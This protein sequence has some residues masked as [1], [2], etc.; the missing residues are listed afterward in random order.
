MES[1][2]HFTMGD[3]STDFEKSPGDLRQEETRAT[4]GKHLLGSIFNHIGVQKLFA[5]QGRRGPSQSVICRRPQPEPQTSFEELNSFKNSE[6]AVLDYSPKDIGTDELGLRELDKVERRTS[7]PFEPE[8]ETTD[9]I[10][11]L[12]VSQADDAEAVMLELNHKSLRL[13]QAQVI[14]HIE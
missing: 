13:L 12:N 1:F 5:S 14:D 2:I 11:S 8:P 9:N 7:N 10:D 4:E 3:A 6:V